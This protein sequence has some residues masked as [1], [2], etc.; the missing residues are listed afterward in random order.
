M[1][2]SDN[3][4]WIMADCYQFVI[5]L[6]L[7]ERVD[8]PLDVFL[9]RTFMAM[10]GKLALYADC[11]RGI[12]LM[13]NNMY[14]NG[15]PDCLELHYLYLE[16]DQCKYLDEALDA[17]HNPSVVLPATDHLG[18][19]IPIEINDFIKVSGFNNELGKHLASCH[20]CLPTL[21]KAA[22]WRDL[23]HELE[24]SS[25]NAEK[26]ETSEQMLGEAEELLIIPLSGMSDKLPTGYLGTVFLWQSKKEEKQMSELRLEHLRQVS[27][28]F[29]KSIER[30]LKVHHEVT[31][32]TYLPYYRRSGPKAVA[33]LFADIRDF[34]PTT[35]ILR[36]FNRVPELMAFMRAYAKR[37]CDIVIKHKGR[38]QGFAGD[39][40]MALFGEYM[41]TSEVAARNA[42]EAGREMI[43][44]FRTIRHEF[45]AGPR[46][47]AFFE[48]EYEPIDCSLGIG[49]NFG[50]VIF[51]YFGHAN[52][53]FYSPVGDHVNFAQ[54]LETKANRFD[55]RSGR[56]LAPILISRPVW[57]LLGRCGEIRPVGLEFKGKPYTYE[58]YEVDLDEKG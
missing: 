39:G 26:K 56:Q 12:H 40:I 44:A 22:N 30:F 55:P 35:E 18:D 13:A 53:R 8:E 32:D 54:R 23:F 50:Q 34:T 42:V 29:S 19:Y 11:D 7:S 48:T 36:N 38:V 47:S 41:E 27:K 43:S 37:M 21:T 5:N 1:S 20:K 57:V 28:V 31:D 6:L 2:S 49:I 45:F 52:G 9:R 51:D 16:A 46:M 24:N 25:G 58:A 10:L 15:K 33:I 14:R 3:G 4:E 17:R